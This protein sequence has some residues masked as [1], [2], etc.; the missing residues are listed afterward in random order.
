MLNSQVFGVKKSGSVAKLP[1]PASALGDDV[2]RG[3][4]NPLCVGLSRR[5]VAARRRLGISQRQ[6]SMAAGLSPNTEGR[7]EAQDNVPTIE[8][9][10]RLASAL[11]VPACWL[12]FGAEGHHA[13][14]EKTGAAEGRTVRLPEAAPPHPF[15]AAF[16]SAPGR[17]RSAREMRGLSLRQI[18]AAAGISLQTAHNCETGANVP[19]VDS[20]ERIAVALDVSPCWLAYGVGEVPGAAVSMRPA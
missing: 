10:E 9:V 4:K 2:T 5:L 20:L 19:R 7:I 3:K 14:R 12:A 16:E 17:L 6:L 13:F 18:S 15:A 1:W 8:T 11:G